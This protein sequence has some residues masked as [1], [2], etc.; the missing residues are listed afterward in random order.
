MK[1][2]TEAPRPVC[3]PMLAWGVEGLLWFIDWEWTSIGLSAAVWMTKK[4]EAG[5]VSG[6]LKSFLLL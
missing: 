6:S 3:P 1:L 5:R 2:T 4:L